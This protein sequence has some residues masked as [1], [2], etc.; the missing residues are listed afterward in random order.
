MLCRETADQPALM[1]KSV[2]EDRRQDDLGET[3]RSL[4]ARVDLIEE[5]FTTQ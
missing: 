5:G 3:L 2:T 4:M 1:S